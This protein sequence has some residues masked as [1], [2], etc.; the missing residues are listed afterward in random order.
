MLF[1]PRIGNANASSILLLFW[2]IKNRYL[3]WC[4]SR[5]LYVCV[6][7]TV[8]VYSERYIKF[9]FMFCLFIW[10][11]FSWCSSGWYQ[12]LLP[13]V[14]SNGLCVVYFLRPLFT[15]IKKATHTNWPSIH[16]YCTYACIDARN[17]RTVSPLIVLKKRC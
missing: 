12:A 3:V 14:V 5:A 9:Y 6:I 8:M 16:S 2:V 10:M 1:F 13:F 15:P 17:S 7:F 4:E 11:I